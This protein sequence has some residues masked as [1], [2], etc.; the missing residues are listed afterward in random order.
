M[1][2]AI[3]DKEYLIASENQYDES[4]KKSIDSNSGQKIWECS[5]DLCVMLQR[6]A[7]DPS[8]KVLELGC[9]HGLPGLICLT[10]GC[11][12]HFQDYSADTIEKFTKQTVML[13]APSHIGSCSFSHG[14]WATFTGHDLYDIILCCEGI[15]ST[16]HFAALKSVLL[17][18][19]RPGTGCAYFAGKKYYFGCGGGTM[20]FAGFV[21]PEFQCEA[22]ERIADGKSNIRE[23]IKI[24]RCQ[25]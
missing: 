20:S 17:N 11:Q 2:L 22:V 3:G 21:A 10:K 9:G 13:N 16:D 23:I 6:L 1:R 19:L 8:C 18:H 7:L 25:L 15:Y 5:Y 24:V 4:S 14:E 12:V